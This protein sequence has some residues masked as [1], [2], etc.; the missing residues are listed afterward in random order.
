MSQFTL[1]S[2]GTVEFTK[3]R[4]T[5]G[6]IMDADDAA[7]AAERAGRRAVY[8]R[9]ALLVTRLT[10]LDEVAWRDLLPE[11]GDALSAEVIRRMRPREEVQ[12]RPFTSESSSTST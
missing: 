3:E 7:G 9:A 12:E 4:P 6:D 1:P 11:D 10:N 8:A 5:W 2:G